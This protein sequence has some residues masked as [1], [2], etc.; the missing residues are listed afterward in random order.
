MEKFGSSST[1]SELSG[2]EYSTIKYNSNWTMYAVNNSEH[3]PLAQLYIGLSAP[4][5][6][7][8]SLYSE[9]KNEVNSLYDGGSCSFNMNGTKTHSGYLPTGYSKT[10]YSALQE[11]NLY[12]GVKSKI[13]KFEKGELMLNSF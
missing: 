10:E 9:R 11:N 13:F 4:C 5:G 1:P 12:D 8:G 7:T 2:L 3:N 6:N